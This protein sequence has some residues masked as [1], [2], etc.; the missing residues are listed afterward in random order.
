MVNS[1]LGAEMAS[2]SEACLESLEILKV[3]TELSRFLRLVAFWKSTE[4]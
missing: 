4:M 3:F 2:N 1:S